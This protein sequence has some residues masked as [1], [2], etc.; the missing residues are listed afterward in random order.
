MP[1]AANCHAAGPFVLCQGPRETFAHGLYAKLDRK[2]GLGVHALGTA[3]PD[4]GENA[5]GVLP[6]LG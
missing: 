3:D 4:L 5:L 2:Q 1:S 6:V